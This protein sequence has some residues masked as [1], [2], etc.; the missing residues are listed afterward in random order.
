MESETHTGNMFTV[1]EKTSFHSLYNTL[2]FF[3]L[4]YTVQ[5]K[6]EDTRRGFTKNLAYFETYKLP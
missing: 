4:S 1:A 6:N 3:T 5:Q 2:Y